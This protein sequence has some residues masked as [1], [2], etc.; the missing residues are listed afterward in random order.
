MTGKGND[1]IKK[2]I[3]NTL[4]LVCLAAFLL[5]ALPGCAAL[6]GLFQ[7]PDYIYE[8]GAVLVGGDDQPVRLVNNP[9]SVNVG[10]AELLEFIRQDSTDRLAYVAPD[11]TDEISPF[12]CSDFAEL[13][14]NNAE[15]SGIRAAY[16]GIDWSEGGLGH[17]VNGFETTDM[18]MVYIDCTGSSIYSQLEE[19]EQTRIMDSWDKVAYI[20]PGKIYGVIGLDYAEMPFYFFFEEYDRRWREFKEKLA[21]YNAE[22]RQYNQEIRGKVFREGS[23]ELERIEAWKARLIQEEKEIESIRAELGD[24]RFKPLGVVKSITVHW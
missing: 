19:G 1:V 22:V 6:E 4:W 13:V 15:V 23:R 18:G 16:V 9:E 8:E 24:S 7:N 21:A 12:V 11:S 5:P 20:E 17:A 10:Y 14:H 3:N 2:H